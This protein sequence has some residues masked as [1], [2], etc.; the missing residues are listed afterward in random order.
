MNVQQLID[1]L[2]KIKN[3]KLPV[4]FDD[5]GTSLRGDIESVQ[6]YVDEEDNDYY[7]ILSDE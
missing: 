1:E 7:V 5:N 3:K 6:T 2:K 4:A